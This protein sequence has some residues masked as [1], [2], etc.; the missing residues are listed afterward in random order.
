MIPIYAAL[1]YFNERLRILDICGAKPVL[2]YDGFNN[3]I[4]ADT[5]DARLGRKTEPDAELGELLKA[6]RPHTFD[7]V[8]KLRK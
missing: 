6:G 1:Q 4:K 7:R 2:V 8:K 3:P 5:R